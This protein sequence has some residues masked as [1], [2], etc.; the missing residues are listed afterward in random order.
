MREEDASCF[1]V[2]RETCA[3]RICDCSLHWHP[4]FSS[5]NLK[6]T[7]QH[8]SRLCAMTSVKLYVYDLSQGMAKQM[9]LGLT[10]RQIGMCHTLH[11]LLASVSVLN[12][13]AC[14]FRRYLAHVCS[15]FRP[16][17]LLWPRHYERSSRYGYLQRFMARER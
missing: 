14:F 7:R 13:T 1:D 17:I 12:S 8:S 4:I 11:P 3:L 6:G 15:C 10:G 2:Y 9:S 16:R 5:Q